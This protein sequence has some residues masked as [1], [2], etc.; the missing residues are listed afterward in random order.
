MD[1]GDNLIG[2]EHGG[3]DGEEPFLEGYGIV[4][5]LQGRHLLG[6]A[7][8]VI[9]HHMDEAHRSA[10]TYFHF[11]PDSTRSGRFNEVPQ[12]EKGMDLDRRA[13]AVSFREE[14]GPPTNRSASDC[15]GDPEQ[16][17]RTWKTWTTLRCFT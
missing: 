1:A 5:V 13:G 2:A 16:E 10:F 3:H 15:A 4:V 12:M 6:G 11:R 8:G 14:S 17:D 9:G 7:Q